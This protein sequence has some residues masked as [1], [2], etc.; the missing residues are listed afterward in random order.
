[1]TWRKL[2]EHAV[3]SLHKG[4]RVVAVGRMRQDEWTTDTGET[5]RRY[6]IDADELAASIRFATV[7][8]QKPQR[9]ESAEPEGIRTR[10]P[11]TAIR[12]GSMNA[13]HDLDRIE[14]LPRG[15]CCDR[16]LSRLR[17]PRR[18]HSARSLLALPGRPP[19]RRSARSPTERPTAGDVASDAGIRADLEQLGVVMISSLPSR[20]LAVDL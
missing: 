10:R 20:Q 17:R 8:V 16:H 12:R 1:M 18:G 2:A 13:L 14:S 9:L 19:L 5:R 6:I 3:S 11:R 4:D 15:A 7:E